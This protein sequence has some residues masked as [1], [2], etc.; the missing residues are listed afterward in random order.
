MSS[1]KEIEMLVARIEGLKSFLE[2]IL[3]NSFKRKY[4]E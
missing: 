1:R 2:T 4:L 3:L